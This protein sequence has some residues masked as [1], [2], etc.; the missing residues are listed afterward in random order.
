LQ[1]IDETVAVEKT[2][3]TNAIIAK[4]TTAPSAILPLFIWDR[5]SSISFLHN[6]QRTML[7]AAKITLRIP[8][9]NAMVL[10]ALNMRAGNVL[11][12]YK[13]ALL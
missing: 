6:L 7:T 1:N 12:E 3:V 9:V 11:R 4:P 5:S 13:D 10:E 2:L 8:V